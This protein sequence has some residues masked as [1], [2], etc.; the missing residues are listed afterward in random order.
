MAIYVLLWIAS[1]INHLAKTNLRPS[2]REFMESLC[3]IELREIVPLSSLRDLML[4]EAKSFRALHSNS[5]IFAKSAKSKSL[6]TIR[7][8]G[9]GGI[10]Y[11]F[12]G[13]CNKIL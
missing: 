7:F 4:D 12:C 13:I 1:A 6:V 2:L 8:C 10:F 5:F 3:C 11:G 9:I